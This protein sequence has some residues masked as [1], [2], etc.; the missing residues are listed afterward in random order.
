M[1][2]TYARS[3]R[4]K[5]C[6]TDFRRRNRVTDIAQTVR[7]LKWQMTGNTARRTINRWERKVL[8]ATADSKSKNVGQIDPAN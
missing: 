3:L 5:I 4:D 8:I 7:M 2:K 1:E 6:N